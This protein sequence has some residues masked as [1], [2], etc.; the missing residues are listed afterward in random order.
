MTAFGTEA[1]PLR[2]SKCGKLIACPMSV[3]L[4][5]G[6]DNGGPAAQ[7]GNL[8]HSAVAAFHQHK[9]VEAGL[10]ALE[11][12]RQQFPKGDPEAARKGYRSYAAD[13]T[14]ADARVPY[15]EQKVRL[16][17]AP[18]P[19]DPTGQRI[20]I[21]GTLDQ[22]REDFVDDRRNA[23]PGLTVWDVKNGSRLDASESLDEHLVQQ[24]VYVLAAR[25]T[26]GL[27]V[28]PGGLILMP[29]YEKP[30]ARRFVPWK[31]T[32]RQ[33][34]LFCAPIVHAVS[35]IRRGIPAFRP[36]PDSCRYCSV[37]PFTH[38]SEMFFGLYGGK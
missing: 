9:D 36:S 1:R 12:A 18:A 34:E 11:A 7:T 15:V 16:D 19:D 10:A 31:L 8:V 38:C 5:D 4:D 2:P 32:A 14:N 27:D 17:L 29:G 35:L 24:A 37:R 25:Q 20:V 33:C 28:K 3:L 26:F 13:K 6:E 21:E 23:Y 30:R 22:I